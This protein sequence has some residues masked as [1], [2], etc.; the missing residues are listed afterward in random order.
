MKTAI[1]IIFMRGWS[2]EA[3]AID[4]VEYD[5]MDLCKNAKAQLISVNKKNKKGSMQYID[6]TIFCTHKST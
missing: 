5:S 1:L 6:T 4:H 3:V 2:G